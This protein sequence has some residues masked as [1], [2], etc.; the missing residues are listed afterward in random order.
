MGYRTEYSSHYCITHESAFVLA[1]P[2]LSLFYYLV[3]IYEMGFGLLSKN[4][5]VQQNGLPLAIVEGRITQTTGATVPLMGR[6]IRPVC[7][8]LCRFLPNFYNIYYIHF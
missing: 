8:P 4:V 6:A 2:M 1:R 5:D 3:E 7:R